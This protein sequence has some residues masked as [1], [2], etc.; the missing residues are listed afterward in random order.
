M[1]NLGVLC[2]LNFQIVNYVFLVAHPLRTIVV[3]G[4]YHALVG[5]VL[6]SNSR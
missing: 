2:G 4:R 3:K 5:V 6:L 1:R